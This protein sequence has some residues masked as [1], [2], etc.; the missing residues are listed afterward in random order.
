MNEIR[1]YV[2]NRGGLAGGSLSPEDEVS[3]S[4][5][6]PSAGGVAEPDSG[7]VL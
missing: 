7:G 2:N 5:T 6:S 3:S 1:T 4:A